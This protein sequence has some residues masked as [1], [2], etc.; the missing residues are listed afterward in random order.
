MAIRV[1]FA[2]MRRFALVG[3]AGRRAAFGRAPKFTAAHGACH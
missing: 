3:R 1:C 2:M